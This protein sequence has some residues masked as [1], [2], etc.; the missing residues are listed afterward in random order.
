MQ[1]NNLLKEIDQNKLELI[2]LAES[3]GNENLIISANNVR[4][5]NLLP[6]TETAQDYTLMSAVRSGSIQPVPLPKSVDLR[7][8]HWTI[9]DQKDTGSCVGWG[10]AD[11]LLTYLFT[12]SKAINPGEKLAA[13]I[14]WQAAK[15]TD[16]Y[17]DFATTFIALEGTSIKAALNFAQ[18]KGVVREVVAPFG[19]YYA[20]DA[21]TFYRLAAQLRVSQIYNLGKSFKN[22]KT[23]LSSAGPIVAAVNVDASFQHCGKDGLLDVYDTSEIYGG[24]CI[25]F[26]GYTEDDRIIIRNSWGTDWGDKGF[27]YASIDWIMK[28]CVESYSAVI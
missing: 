6:S 10:V 1:D 4:I 8:E 2:E 24:H 19:T 28:A 26:V 22:W 7:E 17:T 18:S 16:S 3:P 13:G 11:G 25:C 23:W 27:A 20:K 15:E 9:S 14:L 5:L 21:I 12:K